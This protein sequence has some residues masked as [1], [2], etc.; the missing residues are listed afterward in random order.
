MTVWYPLKKGEKGKM[1]GSYTMSPRF[2]LKSFQFCTGWHASSAIGSNR[3][4]RAI[5]ASIPLAPSLPQV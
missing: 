5:E 1:K 4:W 2:G 3:Q